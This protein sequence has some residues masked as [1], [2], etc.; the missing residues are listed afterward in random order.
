MKFAY[1]ITAH[2]AVPSIAKRGL[3]PRFS[4]ARFSDDDPYDGYLFFTDEEDYVPLPSVF[5]DTLLRFPWPAS[6]DRYVN[7]FG[8]V[9]A[10][11]FVTRETIPPETIELRTPSR[12][13][14]LTDHNPLSGTTRRRKARS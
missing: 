7:Q 1:H 13:V 6:S 9:I 3:I 12:W 10:N 4:G 5:G 14:R 11:Q 8:R 2:A